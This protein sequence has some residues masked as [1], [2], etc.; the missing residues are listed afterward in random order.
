MFQ[1]YSIAI[2]FFV[3]KIKN[4]LVYNYNYIAIYLKQN[5]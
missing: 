3:K 1:D 5:L 2:I 4:D